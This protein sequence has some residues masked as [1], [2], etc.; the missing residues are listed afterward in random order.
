[1]KNIKK[2]KKYRHKT[3]PQNTIHQR[4]AERTKSNLK[5]L[6]IIIILRTM[7]LLLS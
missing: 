1:M 7:I 4:H 5:L 6:Y 2:K 3:H